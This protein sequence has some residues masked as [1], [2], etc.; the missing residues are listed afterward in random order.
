MLQRLNEFAEGGRFELPPTLYSSRPIRY[1]I[2]LD[3][4]GRLLTQVPIDTRELGNQ[5]GPRGLRMMAPSL[6]RSKGI[7]PL[8]LSDNAEY[9][10]G[11][12][13]AGSRSERVSEMHSAYTALVERCAAE[14]GLD[15]VR[16]V[17]RFFDNGGVRSLIL[18]DD[19]EV[20]DSIT[21]R[22]DGK[23]PIESECVQR[24]WSNESSASRSRRLQCLVCG[25]TKPVLDRLPKKINGL[26]GAFSPGRSMVSAN[27]TAAESYGLK[28]SQVA[29]TCVDCAERFTEALNYLLSDESACLL[30][31][32]VKVVFWTR[33]PTRFNWARILASPDDKESQKQLAALC[34]D[35]SQSELED[36]SLYFAALSA[37]GGRAVLHAWEETSLYE[38]EGNLRDWFSYQSTVS[39]EGNGPMPLGIHAL[40]G[41][42]VRELRDTSPDTAVSLVRL[43]L[44]G[45]PLPR[46]QLYRAIHRNR[47]EHRVTRPRVALIRAAL[48]ST[49]SYS[50]LVQEVSELD[51]NV[52]DSAYLSG[53]LLSLLE[54][55]QLELAGNNGIGSL[56]RYLGN[57][58]SS[59]AAVLGNMLR[60]YLPHL[61]RFGNDERSRLG[62]IYSQVVE[63]LL[64][65]PKIPDRLDLEGQGIFALGY[66]HQRAHLR[67]YWRE[68][69]RSAGQSSSVRSSVE[70]NGRLGK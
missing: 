13:H 39:P 44:A 42:T 34:S 60:I 1:L 24:F 67:R 20:K 25:G 10:L 11:I 31:G 41:A 64:S 46:Y 32:S 26:P 49:G 57:A 52:R 16:L 4:E 58:T 48:S 9:T 43:A 15:S 17:S 30:L 61:M 2:D 36:N 62:D 55:A 8:L 5:V 63:T 70:S 56:N 29:P 68:Q 33:S 65:L 12:R 3:S 59:P 45:T 54:D 53:R 37:N 6:S 66:Y 35:D 28:K 47:T 22:V 7:R 14:T 21:F 51:L 69:G 23:L 40:A 27:A 18:E 38:V 19:F 50:Q